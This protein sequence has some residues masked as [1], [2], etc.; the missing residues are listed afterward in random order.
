[1]DKPL[2]FGYFVEIVITKG[3]TGMECL[4]VEMIRPLKSEEVKGGKSP[5]TIIRALIAIW[6]AL[7][8][9]TVSTSKK[10]SRCYVFVKTVP[11]PTPVDLY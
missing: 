2:I 10:F 9:E 6:L 11:K 3:K 1:M 4:W 5:F 7:E 8:S